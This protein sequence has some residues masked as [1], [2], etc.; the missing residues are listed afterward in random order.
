MAANRLKLNACKIGVLW[1]V[2]KHK[3]KD[4]IT[5]SSLNNDK[6]TVHSNQQRVFDFLTCRPYRTFLKQTPM[7]T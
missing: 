1:T 6:C 7:P 3:L 2:T 4:E 5:H